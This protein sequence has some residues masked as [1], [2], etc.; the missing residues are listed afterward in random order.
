MR[1]IS[2]L[3]DYYDFAMSYGVDPTVVYR[4]EPKDGGIPKEFQTLARKYEYYDEKMNIILIHRISILICG[5][6]HIFYTRD[7]RQG[8]LFKT[9]KD[10]TKG[11]KSRFWNIF[12]DSEEDNKDYSYINEKMGGAIVV[13]GAYPHFS[14]KEER[15]IDTFKNICLDQYSYCVDAPIL[16]DLGVADYIPATEI[17]MALDAWFSSRGQAEIENISDKSKIQKAGFDLKQSFRHR[18]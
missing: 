15:V 7:D 8:K 9:E 14:F 10:A 11:L 3:H 4:R 2:K 18:K 6:M 12:P 1:I 17:F 16:K 13:F 5:K